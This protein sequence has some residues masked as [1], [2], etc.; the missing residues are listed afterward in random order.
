MNRGEKRPQKKN[1]EKNYYEHYASMKKK[2]KL[3]N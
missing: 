2:N 3:K 1:K